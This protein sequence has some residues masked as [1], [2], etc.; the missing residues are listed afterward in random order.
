VQA[1]LGDLRSAGTVRE[2]ITVEL[3]NGAE[4]GVE[5]QLEPAAQMR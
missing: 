1:V 3:T 5:V 2:L 4:P